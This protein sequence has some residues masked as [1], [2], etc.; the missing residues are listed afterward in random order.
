MAKIALVIGSP[1][2]GSRLFGL[3]GYVQHKL[4]GSGHTVEVIAASDLPAED[5]LHANFG[6]RELQDALNVIGSADAVLLASPVFKAAYS[7]VLKAILDLLP[8][9]AFR[10]KVVFPLFIGGSIA[11]LLAVD[12]ALKPVV[13]ALGGTHILG[14]VYAVE[15]WITRLEGGGY[16]LDAD[17]KERLNRALIEL[18]EELGRY[19]AV[20]GDKKEGRADLLPPSGPFV[21]K[22]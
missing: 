13:A 17:L 6:S 22:A 3:T 1:T 20:I 16:E 19:T 5:L 9:K 11:H 21:S 4:L 12:Y 14:G 8:Q 18:E 10:G 15:S 7:G 2:P